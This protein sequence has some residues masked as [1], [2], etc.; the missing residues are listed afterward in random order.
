MEG[1]A[2]DEQTAVD[3][4]ALAEELAPRLTGPG[5]DAS[6]AT[7]AA[8]Y[9][10]IVAAID[11][12]VDADRPDEALRIALAMYRFCITQ[13]RF[14]DG[15]RVYGRVLASGQGDRTLRGRAL[16]DA[17]FMPFW[18][19]DDKAARPYSRK[20]SRSPARSAMRQ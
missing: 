6:L 11:W 20:R 13:R 7:L 18:T 3:L 4:L 14:D 9:D 8:R 15:A 2:M 12:F 17:G 5:A 16:L 1:M 19:G 10:E